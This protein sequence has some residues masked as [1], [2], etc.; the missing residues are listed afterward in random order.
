MGLPFLWRVAERNIVAIGMMP[1]HI[2]SRSGKRELL[3]RRGSLVK[4]VRFLALLSSASGGHN[5]ILPDATEDPPGVDG[6][7]PT[8]PIFFSFLYALYSFLSLSRAPHQSRSN[9]VTNIT[10]TGSS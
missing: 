1:M 9:I 7:F 6:T 3:T 5:G 4:H 8:R 2:S 10:I